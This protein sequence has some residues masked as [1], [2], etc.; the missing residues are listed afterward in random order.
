M[1]E[2]K[3]DR[4]SEPEYFD[5][6]ALMR[7]IETL[8]K[9]YPFFEFN[10][11]GN[12]ILGRGIPLISLG[13]GK[14]EVLYVGTHHG[15]EWITAMVLCRFLSDLGELYQKKSTV[16]RTSLETLF[17]THTLYVVPMLNPDGTEYQIHGIKEENPLFSRL[18]DM[19]GGSADFSKWQANARG[20]DLN[21]NYDAGFAEYKKLEAEN[22]ITKGAPT[23]YS[24]EE[25]ESE[26]EVAALCNFIRFRRDLR[27][28]LTL[29]T[30]GEEIFYKSGGKCAKGAEGVA[31]K[32]SDLTGYRLSLAEGLASYGGLTDWCAQKADIPSFT[33]ECGKGV[34]PLPISDH[35][36]IYVN[37]RK[38]LFT[39]P[40]LLS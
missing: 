1:K 15:M 30:Q 14:R 10:Y 6:D 37:L 9:K 38:V 21:H 29:H 28:I 26:P 24:G 39:C 31:K 25:P 4:L 18:L 34:N 2:N 20:V 32:L 19:N 22:G 27:G 11:L 40:T 12:S 16:Y 7:R 23:R 33:L 5:H 36:P 35:F 13:G 17:Q 8:V 3:N